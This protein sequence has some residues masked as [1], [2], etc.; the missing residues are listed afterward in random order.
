MKK[1]WRRWAFFCLLLIL[2]VAGIFQ[3]R[4]EFRFG[5]IHFNQGDAE[6]QVPEQQIAL[7]NLKSFNAI[8]KQ[9]FT[10]LDRGR[11]SFVF[12][13]TDGRYVL[14]FFDAQCLRR[15]FLSR[16]W[17][18]SQKKCRDRVQKLLEGYLVGYEVDLQ[19]SGLLFL[20]VAPHPE[21]LG[22][23]VSVKDRFGI[24][25]DIDLGKVPF[26]IQYKAVPTRVKLTELLQKRD[27]IGVE[28]LF[29]QLHA[30]YMDEYAKG[31][32]DGDHNFMYNTG[33]ADGNAMRMDLGRLR[34]D[35]SM[36][37]P[38]IYQKDLQI[39]NKRTQGWMG[40]HFPEQEVYRISEILRIGE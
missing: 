22:K 23:V 39:L 33:F 7:Q 36:K 8:I 31:I 14:K 1:K 26:A 35:E 3:W 28:R 30:M 20:Q 37:D 24:T 17:W 19:Y 2:L 6:F 38:A 40:R 12:E 29:K 18:M 15:D 32:Y 11:Q 25:H 5:N 9:P 21:L 4:Q 34:R 16:F 13:S 10:Y 27:M